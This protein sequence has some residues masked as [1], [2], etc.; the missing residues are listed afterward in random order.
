M[1]PKG[2]GLRGLDFSPGSR[3][4]EPGDPVLGFA[5]PL[6][7]AVGRARFLSLG[8]LPGE[9]GFLSSALSGNADLCFSAGGRRWVE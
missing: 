7:L 3:R 8:C 4:V 5:W 9:Q 2:R 6:K 1:L